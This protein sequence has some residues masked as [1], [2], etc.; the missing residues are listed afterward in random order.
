MPPDSKNVA[1]S[2]SIPAVA[3]QLQNSV[4]QPNIPQAPPLP[5]PQQA[6]QQGQQGQAQQN[7]AQQQPAQQNQAQ[8]GQVQQQPAQQ[9][10]AQQQ[11]A[12]Q[13]QA[14]PAQQQPAQQNQAQQQPAQQNQAQPA[15]QQPD[16]LE[17]RKATAFARA[18]H[19]VK[20]LPETKKKKTG[21]RGIFENVADALSAGS[22]AVVSS[23]SEESENQ[24][25]KSTEKANAALENYNDTDLRDEE[26]LKKLEEKRKK[27]TSNMQLASSI[28]S[29]ATIGA[30]V[31]TLGKN[32]SKITRAKKGT[33]TKATLD[34]LGSLAKSISTVLNSI[35]LGKAKSIE[36]EMDCKDLIAEQQEA[37]ALAEKTEEE[38]RAT[39]RANKAKLTATKNMA[40]AY[41]NKAKL[42]I[43]ISNAAS[44]FISGITTLIDC[45][46]MR[47]RY[48]KINESL[49]VNN[50][51]NAGNAG[52]PTIN[53]D[54]EDLKPVLQALSE[55]E[56]NSYG[57][58]V[59]LAGKFASEIA[60][61]VNFARDPDSKSTLIS[62]IALSGFSAASDS[63][64]EKYDTAKDNLTADS[65]VSAAT[66]SM[67]NSLTDL[68]TGSNY[69]GYKFENQNEE[70]EITATSS[71][72]EKDAAF[73][74]YNLIEKKLSLLN[75]YPDNI[76]EAS[77][78]EDLQTI[79]SNAIGY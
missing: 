62:K 57:Y 6:Q 3:N 26:T 74:K 45:V 69:I 71:D 68:S 13:N 77:S 75:V 47:K 63:L 72:A 48:N 50:A 20:N 29:Y 61:A 52:N 64:K 35:F 56:N 5:Q 78:K 4:N 2:N 55:R 58:M 38:Q 79:I 59:M 40:K 28:S 70:G 25:T 46:N 14:Q 31:F 66:S 12:Q 39:K 37:E 41:N 49:Y 11:P 19:H 34:T 65:D 22:D 42:A 16:P 33:K 54:F 60:Y 30:T 24:K 8:P 7:Q 21:K 15:Q 23:A 51:G 1:G 67:F 32:I 43:L 36:D 44:T 17:T 76:L 53:K 18:V 27:H 10:Q 73:E 9:N